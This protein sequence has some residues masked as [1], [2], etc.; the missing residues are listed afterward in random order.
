MQQLSHYILSNAGLVG[1]VTILSEFS[2]IKAFQK[3]IIM[4][5]EEM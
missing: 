3:K 4:P 1:G 5:N 2:Q